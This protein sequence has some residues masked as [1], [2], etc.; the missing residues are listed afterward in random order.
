M[1]PT[2]PNIKMRNNALPIIP[3]ERRIVRTRRSREHQLRG[4][5]ICGSSLCTPSRDIMTPS[6]SRTP[7]INHIHVAQITT[8]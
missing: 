1:Y 6:R 5:R 3:G 7:T 2:P 8:S 4:M